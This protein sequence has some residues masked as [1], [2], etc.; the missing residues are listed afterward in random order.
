MNG[1]DRAMEMFERPMDEVYD[2]IG[3]IRDIIEKTSMKL[4]DV[5]LSEK[6]WQELDLL[7]SQALV[8]LD[9]V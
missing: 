3:S 5:E 7:L 2:K 4:Y 1:H 9:E 6:D 8:K